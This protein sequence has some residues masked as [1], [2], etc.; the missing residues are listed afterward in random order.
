MILDFVNSAEDIQEAFQPF[1]K[2]AILS[3]KT[4]PNILYDLERR[5]E[6]YF[7]FERQDVEDFAMVY[8]KP[9]TSQEM[10]HAILDPVV[11]VY[12]EEVYKKQERFR[13]DLTSYVRLYSFLSHIITFT[14]ADLEKLY[15]F[16]RFLLKKLPTPRNRLPVEIEEK[17]DM[18]LYRIQETS[19]GEIKLLDTDGYLQSIKGSGGKEPEKKQM[20]PLSK[21]VQYM[22]E[23]YGF[24]EDEKLQHFFDDIERRLLRN[25]HLI[26]MMNPEINPPENMRLKF[27]EIFDE[28][29]NQMI[30]GNLEL[31]GKVVDNEDLN[32]LFKRM[33][34][35]EIYE[36]IEDTY[37]VG[38]K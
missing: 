23:Q 8:F 25:E 35:L 3:E 24:T 9:G 1:Y 29:L 33:M 38:K 28:T 19:S 20:A 30:N 21:I 12:K 16:S 7:I 22:N 32:K 34:F 10:L 2:T 36:K 15:Q 5:L 11:K 13:K 14:D 18:N 6:D 26:K 4:D 37:Q 27:D 17:I 31:Y